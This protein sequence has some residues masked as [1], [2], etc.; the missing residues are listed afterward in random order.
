MLLLGRPEYM[1]LFYQNFLGTTLL[2]SLK[3]K[4]VEL[5]SNSNVLETIQRSA[6][7]CLQVGWMVLLPTAE[8]R[9]RA[10]SALLPNSI[11]LSDSTIVSN[12][13][14]GKR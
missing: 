6:Q 4:V 9:A 3:T 10:L 7:G 13:P 8:E 11:P 14:N 1:Y 2:S 12:I 5:A